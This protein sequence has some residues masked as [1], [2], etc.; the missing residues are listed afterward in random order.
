MDRREETERRT[1]IWIIILAGATVL[2]TL[3]ILVMMFL[4]RS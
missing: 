2:F 4:A 3:G 1:E